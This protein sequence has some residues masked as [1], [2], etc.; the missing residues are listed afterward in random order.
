M[1]TFRDWFKTIAFALNDDEPG[2][3]F[4]R[5][6]LK[7]MVAAYNDAMCLV[8]KYRQDLFTEYR[9]VELTGG[10]YQDMRGC[11]DQILDVTDQ[12]DVDGNVIKELQGARVTKTKVKRNWKKPSC[13]ARPGAPDGYV[14]DNVDID[15][16]MNGRFEVNPPVPCDVKAYV[17]VKC[18]AGPCPLGMDGVEGQ[19][20]A[21]CDMAVAAWHFV[22]ARMQTGDRFSNASAQA[23]QYNNRMFFDILGVVQRQEDLMESPEKA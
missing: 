20:N 2:H 19:V 7:Q 22:L 12:T 23:V 21:D 17:R 3:E 18:V 13:I 1:T 15:G 5:Y 14:I 11:C 4:S 6:P 16:N 8:Y 9:I 10:K